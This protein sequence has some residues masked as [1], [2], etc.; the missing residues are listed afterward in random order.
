MQIGVNADDLDN[1]LMA[2]SVDFDVAGTGV[3]AAA[4]AKIQ[5]NP[6]LKKNADA[7]PTA[8][9]WLHRDLAVDVAPFDNIHCRRAVEYATDKAAMQTAWGGP[10]VRR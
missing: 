8:R 5:S 6:T 1:R 3:Q 10:L 9:R 4:A 7:A 2:G